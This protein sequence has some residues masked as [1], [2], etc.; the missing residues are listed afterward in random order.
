MSTELTKNNYFCFHCIPKGMKRIRLIKDDEDKLTYLIILAIACIKLD[1]G[2][3]AFGILNTHF[4]YLVGIKRFSDAKPDSNWLDETIKHF[5][6]LVNR[7]Y[8]EFFRKKYS[9][10]GRIFLKNEDN[11]K[12]VPYSDGIKNAIAYIHNNA[13]SI[14]KFAVYEDDPF[15]SYNYYLAAFLHND[16]FQQL[17]LIQEIM[18]SLESL[19]IFNALDLNFG[20]KQF[21]KSKSLQVSV[22]E[23]LNVHSNSLIL[24]DKKNQNFNAT[25]RYKDLGILPLLNERS[26][27]QIQETKG[28][29]V[30]IYTYSLGNYKE[31]SAENVT[32]PFQKFSSLFPWHD[33]SDLKTSY[34][35]IR[36]T[37]EPEFKEFIKNISINVP[38]RK[39]SEIVG[40]SREYVRSVR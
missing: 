36:A 20:L 17:P 33:E 12:Y 25:N 27:L 39:V 38:I 1:L 24:R 40:V 19:K 35:R 14:N 21:S 26:Q 5:V 28:H 23:F 37:C 4:H 29:K 2:L 11:Y 6:W 34:K 15:N 18:T 13:T 9:H 16:E 30:K 8:G 3:L 22:N 31:I 10:S 7:R 32:E